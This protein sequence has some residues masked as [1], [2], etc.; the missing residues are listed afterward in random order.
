[1]GLPCAHI[2]QQRLQQNDVLKLEDIHSHWYLTPQ[3]SLMAQPLILEPAIAQV[4][5]HPATSKPPPTRRH[6]RAALARQAA[7]STR[8][9]PSAFERIEST[10]PQKKQ[11]IKS[12]HQTTKKRDWRDDS[13]PEGNSEED[14]LM[15]VELQRLQES[16]GTAPPLWATM[17]EFAGISHA[18]HAYA[19]KNKQN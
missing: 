3:T 16:R 13:E 1:M 19:Q 17:P 9:A 10:K 18:T 12:K 6:N 5:G 11:T 2:I 4:R 14:R 15:A 8:R 7:S